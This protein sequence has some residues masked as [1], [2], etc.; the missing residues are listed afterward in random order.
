M[1]TISFVF[2]RSRAFLRSKNLSIYIVALMFLAVFPTFSTAIVHAQTGPIAAYSFSEGTGLSTADASGNGKTGTLINGPTW[3]V[4]G[5]Y[6]NAL[7]YDGIN[8]YVSIPST[9]DVAAL[10]FTLSAWVN[11]SNYNDYGTIIT[12][13]TTYSPSGMRFDLLL[14]QGSGQVRLQSAIS[15]ITFGYTPP[16]ATWTHIAVV[17]STTNTQLYVNGA[18]Q[19]SLG[20]FTLG[21]DA[22]AQVRIGNAPDGPDQYAGRL[23]DLRI[24][25]R[26]L[27]QTEVQT[28]MNTPVP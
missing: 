10:P 28:D 20:V 2:M 23:D 19:Q 12:K 18:L 15:D 13:R 16:L 8:D 7:S 17:M 24:Y 21:N 4:A 6:G 22:T 3:T 1:K 14:D 26:A 5:K 27:T 11:P 9:L 25:N